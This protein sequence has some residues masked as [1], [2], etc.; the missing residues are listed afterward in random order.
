M[1]SEPETDLLRAA[2]DVLLDP[3]TAPAQADEL[4]RVL[5]EGDLFADLADDELA[6]DEPGEPDEDDGPINE[7]IAARVQAWLVRD[8]VEKAGRRLRSAQPGY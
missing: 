1:P 3:Q 4:T 2:V 7:A 8:A 5:A 6:D